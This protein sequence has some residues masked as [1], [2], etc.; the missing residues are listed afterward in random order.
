M[1]IIHLWRN[2]LFKE[3]TSNRFFL[4]FFRKATPL[5]IPLS[6]Y[7]YRVLVKSC[8]SAL[9]SGQSSNISTDTTSVAQI[10]DS[11]PHPRDISS[12]PKWAGARTA[13]RCLPFQSP[14]KLLHLMGN[15]DVG[16]VDIFRFVVVVLLS[17]VLLFPVFSMSLLL[18]L[19]SSL[20][21]FY[22]PS[23]VSLRGI[24]SCTQG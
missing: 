12:F 7:Y 15:K 16:N 13:S 20:M 6:R 17:Q 18:S 9:T 14:A 8:P 21:L 10:Q 3:N 19:S 4:V 22:I 24:Q 5:K 23:K 11:R 1:Q 2:M